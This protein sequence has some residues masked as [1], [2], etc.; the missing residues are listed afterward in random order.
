MASRIWRSFSKAHHDSHAPVG[1][2][3][4]SV[5][6]A[7]DVSGQ[8]AVGSHI[9]QMRVDT[10]L[11]NLVTVLPP[12]AKAKVT[13]RPVPISLV[14]RRPAFLVGRQNETARAVEALAARRAIELYGP[15]GIGKSTLLRSLAHQLPISEACGGM[16]HLSARGL[17][18]DD[19]LQVMF[20]VFY[21]TD[22]PVKPPPGELRHRLQHVRAALLLDDVDLAEDDIEDVEDYA[23]ECG[24]I[25]TTGS[26]PGVS[27]ALTIPLTG[28]R[29]PDARE[30]IAHAL[31]RPLG[32]EEQPAVDAMCDLVQGAP[33]G[34]LRLAAAARDH[35]G[36]L[37]EF[38]ET[39]ASAGV[40]PIPVESAEDVRVLGLL[41]AVPGVHLDVRQLAEITGMTDLQARID[42][43]VARGLVLA[44]APPVSSAAPVDYSLAD[45]VDLG[46]A[47]VWQMTQRRAEL[48]DYF[49]RLS[50][51]RSETLL[52]PGAPPETLRA[53]HSDAAKRHEWRYV[54]GL[55][56]LLDAAYALS[57]RWDAWREVSET[58]LS[59]ARAVGDPGAEAM[60]L[61]Q[62]GTR[63]LCEGQT[64]ISA[65]LLRSALDLRISIGAVAA[66][67]VTHHNLSL[68]MLPPLSPSD[69]HGEAVDHHDG[70]SQYADDKGASSAHTSAVDPGSSGA[71]ASSSGA[72]TS[73]SGVHASVGQSGISVPALTA[74]ASLVVVSAIVAGIAILRSGSDAAVALDERALS[75][76]PV[77]LNQVSESRTLTARNLAE[78]RSTW[79]TSSSPVPTRRSS[80]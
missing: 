24:F 25:L 65:D 77:A 43:L 46:P 34:L 74:G 26:D 11:G 51:E 62:L 4:T 27:E 14:P 10:V 32:P 75:F 78:R 61:H 72:Q 17:S 57:G 28:L 2:V 64:S 60:A 15:A 66:A 39:A 50:E 73:S 12:D 76:S 54:L 42:R 31:G 53:L 35:D 68:I 13:P 67:Q 41:A 22:I 59:A 79:T 58:M 16:A 45:G 56:V 49:L 44:S 9:V 23:P 36:T 21:S 48:R 80:S 38:A 71:Q 29:G 47:G 5:T 69:D 30:L 8:L 7:G 63:A 20:D 3:R 70:A 52:A 55:G 33:A 37:A 19:L 6:V 40:P 18:H 1:E